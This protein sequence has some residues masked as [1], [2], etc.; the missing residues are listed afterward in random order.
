M[1]EP[2]D[3]WETL[4][5]M[6]LRELVL[7]IYRNIICPDNTIKTSD[8]DAV[9]KYKQKIRN[10]ENAFIFISTNESGYTQQEVASIFN[11]SQVAIQKRL[12]DTT[13]KVR[14]RGIEGQ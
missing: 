6:F 10:L 2:S 12:K 3:G 11:L 13:Q 4:E 8:P 14:D 7:A 9:Y 5:R 1:S